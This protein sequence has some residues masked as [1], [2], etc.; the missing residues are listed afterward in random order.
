VATFTIR[1]PDSMA[2]QLGSAEVRDWLGDF[3][4][5]PRQLPDDPGS[6]DFRVSLTLPEEL[7]RSL[8]AQLG[9]SPSTALRRLAAWRLGIW[10]SPAA[11]TKGA[12]VMARGSVDRRSPGHDPGPGQAHDGIPFPPINGMVLLIDVCVVL[13]VIGVMIFS[14]SRQ[15][16]S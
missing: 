3:L 11:Q 8:A 15:A 12:G 14:Q 1:L 16:N 10:Q 13:I 4:R 5:A 2:G 7:V 6:G 9:C